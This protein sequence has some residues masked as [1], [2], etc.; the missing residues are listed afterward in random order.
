MAFSTP[1]WL[2]AIMLMAIQCLTGAQALHCLSDFDCIVDIGGADDKFFTP[3]TQLPPTT[4]QVL[5]TGSPGKY[6]TTLE[7]DVRPSSQ[8]F[9]TE[10]VYATF[11][12][13]IGLLHPGFPHL[14][15][16]PYSILISNSTCYYKEEPCPGLPH[17]EETRVAPWLRPKSTSV[18]GTFT[19]TVTK[20]RSRTDCTPYPIT[21]SQS[22][23]FPTGTASLYPF[24]TTTLSHSSPAS[25]GT[26]IP[27]PPVMSGQNVFEPISTDPIPANIPARNDHPLQKK[28]IWDTPGPVSTNKFYANFFIGSQA[29]Y[30]FV[31][32]YA[33]GWAK[34][35]A[36]VKS[37]G[38][39]ISHIEADKLAFGNKSD[40]I[41]GNPVQ[42]YINPIGIQAMILSASE[43]DNSTVLSVSKPLAFSADI[44]LQPQS[45]STSNVTFPL[46]QGMG[47]VTGVYTNLQPAI[48]SGVFF[49][50]LAS[51]AP[52]RP[53]I[54]KYRISLENS[55]TWLIYVTPENGADPKLELV[56][57]GLIRGPTGFKGTI[58]IAKNPKG[59]AG[60]TIYDRS[61]G[62]YATAA[63][64]TGAVSASDKRGSYK[65]AWEKAGKDVN[66][67]QL[68]M[69]ALPHH[70]Q[71][72]DTATQG[73]KTDMLMRTTT[74]GM[75]TA[76]VGDSW[77]MVEE[78]LP[79]DIGF[80][81]QILG[82]GTTDL[83]EAAK[84][85]IKEVAPN[86][87]SQDI[88]QQTNLDSMYFSGKALAK[89][90]MLVYTVRELAQDI[91]LS[92]SPFQTLKDAFKTFVDNKQKFPL[93]YDEVWKGV[94]SSG[95]YE[96]GDPGLDFGNAFYNDHHFH[97]GYFILA[98]AIIGHFEPSWI[99]ANK[100]W[101]NMLVRDAANSVSGDALFPFSR[102]FDW[103]NGHSW[104]KGLFESIDGKDQESTS[105]DTMF[106][107]AIKMWGKTSG[108][109]S[110][111]A[112][113]NLM[114]GILSRTLNNYF[115][116][117]SDNVN[118]PKEFI[119]NKVTGILFEN[120]AEHTTYFGANLE[121]I[122]GIHMLPLIPSSG[123]T[124][125]KDFV[126]EEWDAMF[127]EQASTSASKVQGGWQ[128]VL[129]ANL[130][131]IDP[132][133]SWNFFA[134]EPFD[135]AKVDGGA[136]RTWYLAYAAG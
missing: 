51:A 41:P 78:D 64:M 103:Y 4:V 70:V 115:L 133:A 92:E 44:I 12:E 49:R 83:S 122:H 50:E 7:R 95:T 53:G 94:V 121:Y 61:A 79:I 30:G 18:L 5:A 23:L 112:R 13:R 123:Y 120:K 21:G 1:I 124:R 66:S 65:L 35:S 71:S 104:A 87:L 130:A 105:E 62:V 80:A 54:F 31:H 11:E 113:G 9:P 89:F 28:N 99:D 100:V 128:G 75:A 47:F 40:T 63:N 84:Q 67:T 19:V 60:E 6:C 127:S 68:L 108:D 3:V 32:P 42:C 106:A 17:V 88:H 55:T 20:T 91:P 107:Y 97:Y 135:L 125:S 85:K 98:A 59:G 93:V 77:T 134:Q 25:S 46:V 111:E 96:T 82:S 72:F 34:G 81:P 116:M 48:Q 118:Q 16:A 109:A 24:P 38:L 119:G 117:K 26:S 15:I 29:N 86:E 73:M 22:K 102:G 43:L 10:I 36:P 131:I 2:G 114:L 8:P 45:N 58:Q 69:F 33:V 14:D 52:P 110:M 57:N 101:V 76:C 129:Y 90:A 27:R 37:D 74:K 136:S 39:V 132:T 126:R 56:D